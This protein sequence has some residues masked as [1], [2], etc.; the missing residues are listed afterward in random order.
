MFS[1]LRTDEQL[2]YTVGMNTYRAW[3]AQ[4]VVMYARSTV[5]ASDYLDER[6]EAFVRAHAEELRAMSA[7]EFGV[8]KRAL[9]DNLRVHDSNLGEQTERMWSEIEM[10]DCRFGRTLEL[11]RAVR[12]LTLDDVMELY[13]RVLLDPASRRKMSVWVRAPGEGTRPAPRRKAGT[14]PL[15]GADVLDDAGL[16]AWRAA[17]ELLPAPTA[18]NDPPPPPPCEDDEGAGADDGAAAPSDEAGRN[19]TLLPDGSSSGDDAESS[20]TTPPPPSAAPAPA[21]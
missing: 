5:V 19:A 3:S 9:Q 8:V 17:R 6:I 11:R 21:A 13:E 1:S 7:E 14:E 2:G 12:E 15:E 4:A 16:D 20:L 10:H 18:C